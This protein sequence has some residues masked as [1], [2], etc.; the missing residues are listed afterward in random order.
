MNGEVV[1]PLAGLVQNRSVPVEV[2]VA[3]GDEFDGRVNGAHGFGVSDEVARV[4]FGVGVRAHPV[5]PDFVAD[6]PELP[7]VGR[8]VAVRRAHRAVAR[9]GRAVAILDPRGGLFRGRAAPLDVDRD[10]R[11][12]PGGAREG[13]VLV[14]AEVAR[15]R[16][17][18]PGEVRPYETL[19]ARADSPEPAV[20]L[21]DVAA[22]PADE[23]GPQRLHTLE[24]VAAPAARPGARRPQCELVLAP[25]A[26][27]V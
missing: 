11:L 26:G 24:H 15:L 19:I 21:R 16:L 13:D 23:G 6:L 10:R 2:V 9:R 4:S 20:V 12:G 3:D 1:N 27:D 25:V 8:G 7:A 14:R 5:A 18:L 22:R 17:V